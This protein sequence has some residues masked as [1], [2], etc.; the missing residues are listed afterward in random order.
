[1]TA[2]GK[3]SFHDFEI[4]GPA[5]VGACG[6]MG[7]FRAVRREDGLPVLLHR[8]R[9]AAILMEHDPSLA[10]ARPQDLGRTFLTGFIAIIEVAGSAYLV[11]PFPEICTS[12]MN[13]WR[14]LLRTSPSEAR[15]FASVVLGRL[16]NVANRSLLALRS[17]HP[18]NL[19]LTPA[20][21]LGILLAHLDT[22]AGQQWLR[23]RSAFLPCSP[24]AAIRAFVYEL[25][26]EETAMSKACGRQLLSDDDR[27]ELAPLG[28]SVATP[29]PGRCPTEASQAS[30]PSA[31]RSPR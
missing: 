12:L 29:G 30:R 18:N 4:R 5:E 24:L 15:Q 21:H 27:S 6:N 8:F 22:S 10:T 3:A 19:I 2:T 28:F 7:S 14:E 16:Y 25:L 9:P 20:G 1:M 13:V 26:V 11:E 17:I 31:G 23:P